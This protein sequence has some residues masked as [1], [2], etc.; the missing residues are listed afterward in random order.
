MDFEDGIDAPPKRIIN[1]RRFW[2][3]TAECQ[4]RCPYRC[5]RRGGGIICRLDR[6]DENDT[7]ETTTPKI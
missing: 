4:P 6:K 5:T 2:P 3:R 1:G 7:T